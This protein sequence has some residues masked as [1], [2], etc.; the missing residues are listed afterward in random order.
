[1]FTKLFWKDAAERA[2][3]TFLQNVAAAV[4]T[5]GLSGL[6][7]AGWTTILLNAAT[8]TVFSLASSVLSLPVNGNG[9]ASLLRGVKAVPGNKHEA[10]SA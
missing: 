5:I 10:P 6:L 8:A 7:G 2:G 9:T 1:M 4:V 3:K